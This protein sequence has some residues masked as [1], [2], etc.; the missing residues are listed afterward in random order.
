MLRRDGHLINFVGSRRKHNDDTTEPDNYEYDV[1]HEGHWGKDSAWMA[2]NMPRLLTSNVPDVA[3]IHLGTE[4]ILSGK[5]AAEPLTDM[6]V[7]NIDTVIAALRAKNENVKIVLS[8]IIPAKAQE[9]A[10]K[11]LNTKLSRYVQSPATPQ[12]P[13]L[14]ADPHDGFDATRDLTKDGALPTSTAAMKM[15]RV[16]A[17]VINRL[18]GQAKQK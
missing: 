8:K 5:I 1:D 6:I 18:V 4:D 7:K 17:D 11:L 15:A 13:L 10:V 2:E 9:E 12:Q 3:V 14:L 16:F